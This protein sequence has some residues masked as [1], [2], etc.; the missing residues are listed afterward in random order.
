MPDDVE[1]MGD[2]EV[3]ELKLVA[4]VGEQVQDLGLGGAA[5]LRREETAAIR[6]P[7]LEGQ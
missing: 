1:V 5:G 3:A 4:E 7:L 2:E 6:L